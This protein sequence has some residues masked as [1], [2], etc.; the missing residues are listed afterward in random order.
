MLYITCGYHDLMRLTNYSRKGNQ[1]F[2]DFVMGQMYRKHE[3]CRSKMTILKVAHLYT[4]SLETSVWNF[5]LKMNI[6]IILPHMI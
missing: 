1:I 3:F 5:G 2:R 4:I 6:F